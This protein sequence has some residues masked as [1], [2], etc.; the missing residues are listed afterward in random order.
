MRKD[1]S[2]DAEERHDAGVGGK[3]AKPAAKDDRVRIEVIGRYAKDKGIE[4]YAF[5][6]RRTD[7]GKGRKGA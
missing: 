5:I 3:T 1:D 2:I 6:V 7:D 4:P